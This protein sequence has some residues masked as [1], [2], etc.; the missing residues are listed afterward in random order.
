MRKVLH[1]SYGGL[2]NGGVS[3]VILSITEPLKNEYEFGCVVYRTVGMRESVFA[4][5]GHLHRIPCYSKDGKKD[6]L[7]IITRPF[8][9]FLGVFFICKKYGYDVVHVHNGDDEGLCLFAAKCAGVKCRIAHS[10][11][12]SSP[13]KKSFIKVALEKINRCFV[14]RFSTDRVGCSELACRDYYKRNDFRVIYNAI[15][16]DK[17]NL[18]A[19][20]EHDNINF[21]HVGRF[22]YQK[23]QSY[24][25][26]IFSE[27]YKR[28]ANARLYLIGFGEDENDLRSEIEQ[29]EL[30][31]VVEIV[32]GNKVSVADYYAIADYMIFPSRYEGFGIVLIEAQAFGIKC[33]VSDAV[34][35]EANVGLLSFIDLS[36]SPAEWAGIILDSINNGNGIN[37]AD[38]KKKLEAYSINEITKKYMQLY[39]GK[40]E[41]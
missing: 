5:Y 9:M 18:E 40:V 33:F 25:I 28:N 35:E 22:C 27:I 34:Q 19:R 15:D 38:L 24:V 31:A 20:R 26:K 39:R 6:I 21:V 3:S 29:L 14:D 17:Y 8:R 37:E 12:T 11:N 2:G 41:N 7:E 1:V 23:N 13:K 4:E 36:S 10:H 16:L 32:P 30:A